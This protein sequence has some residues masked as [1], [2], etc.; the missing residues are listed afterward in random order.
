M[1]YREIR[2]QEKEQN[3]IEGCLWSVEILIA[4]H[5]LLFLELFKKKKKTQ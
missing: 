2:G 5:L 3:D 4:I 1:P